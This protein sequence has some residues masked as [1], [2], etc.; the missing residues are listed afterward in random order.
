MTLV[1]PA[2]VRACE[3]ISL[4]DVVLQLC[5]PADPQTAAQLHDRALDEYGT[6]SRGRLDSV[7]RGLVRE[8][9][10]RFEFGGYVRPEAET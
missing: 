8:G 9:R 6:C 3:R 4:I 10:L 2:E 7:L 5:D 1:V